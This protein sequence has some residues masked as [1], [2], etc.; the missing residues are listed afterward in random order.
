[1]D[2]LAHVGPSYP[3]T[4]LTDGNQPDT[5]PEHAKAMDRILTEKNIDHVFNFYEASEV[6]LDHG[7]PGRL[8]SKHGRDNLGRTIEFIR[9][10]T[11]PSNAGDTP[12]S[13]GDA[14]GAPYA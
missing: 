11:A 8:G 9:Q 5:F 12:V 6:A 4:Y 10:R 1:M 2:V 13:R 14:V 7:Y 3:A